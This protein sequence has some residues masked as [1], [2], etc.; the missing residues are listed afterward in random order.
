[1]PQALFDRYRGGDPD[2]GRSVRSAANFVGLEVPTGIPL[3][4]LPAEM[5]AKYA[6]Q[7][8]RVTSPD[9]PAGD[10]AGADKPKRELKGVA[11]LKAQLYGP[12]G[13]AQEAA[14]LKN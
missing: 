4:R 13:S 6:K 1:M 8:Q 10:A 7:L 9:S 2:A 14:V 5:A 12:P 3:G 11:S